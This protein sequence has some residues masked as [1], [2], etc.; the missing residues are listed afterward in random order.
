MK[1]KTIPRAVAGL[2]ALAVCLGNT[3]LT[4]LAAAPNETFTITTKAFSM[5]EGEYASIETTAAQPLEWSAANAKIVDV[6]GGVVYGKKQGSTK[7]T[8]KLDTVKKSV[9]V[10]VIRSTLR[11][12][13]GDITLY[14]GKDGAT[15]FKLKGTVRGAAKSV[16]F[17]SSDPGIATV[18]AKGSVTGVSEGTALITARAN[19]NYA[20]CKVN[21]LEKGI[22]LNNSSLNLATKG[23]G[24]SIKLTADVTGPK[25]SVK[26]TT[27]DKKV[28]TVSGGTVRGRKEGSAVITATANGVSTSCHVTVYGPET[29]M[30]QTAKG[31]RESKVFTTYG[32]SE[33]QVTL[34]AGMKRADTKQ[35]KSSAPKKDKP[36]WVSSD[37]N[38][39]QVN[40]NGKLTAVGAGT[41]YVCVTSDATG[42]TSGNCR[43]DV[44]AS[45]V[46][47]AEDSVTVKT[48]GAKQK[49]ALTSSVCGKKKN[50]TW[51]SSNTKV[52]TVSKGIVTGKKEGTAVITAT[53]NGVSD[54]VT[55]NVAAYDDT[56]R[57]ADE[58]EKPVVHV[59]TWSDWAVSVKAPAGGMGTESRY[60]TTCKAVQKRSYTAPEQEE[61][62]E[63]EK[64]ETPEVPGTPETPEKDPAE[65]KKPDC[66]Y[67]IT[68]ESHTW[69]EWKDDAEVT[70]K[71]GKGTKVRTCTVCGWKETKKPGS[72]YA[73]PGCMNELAPHIWGEWLWDS[74]E[75]NARGKKTESR[76]C[77]V[78]GKNE[79]R[80]AAEEPKKDEEPKQD[81]DKKDE[82]PKKDDES[83]KEPVCAGD[84]APHTWG[85]WAYD[86]E[87][88]LSVGIE[89][90]SRICSVCNMKDLRKTELK[91]DDGDKKDDEGQKDDESQTG[92]D[93]KNDGDKKDDESGETSETV[94]HWTCACG[95]EFEDPDE[96]M[97]TRAYGEHRNNN[98]YA[99]IM[100]CVQQPGRKW[101]GPSGMTWEEMHKNDPIYHWTCACG[102]DF[103]DRD[104][105]E[106]RSNLNSHIW[107]ELPAWYAI[108]FSGDIAFGDSLCA[109][110]AHMW[111]EYPDRD[112][113]NLSE[114]VKM[115]VI[116]LLCT[117]CG[118]DVTDKATYIK[119]ETCCCD[120][121]G[122]DSFNIWVTPV[123][124]DKYIEPVYENGPKIHR[125][126][127]DPE[128]DGLE[129]FRYSKGKCCDVHGSSCNLSR[130]AANTEAGDN[131]QTGDNT[132]T[133]DNTQTGDN[134]TAV[135]EPGEPEVEEPAPEVPEKK[136]VIK[137][138]VHWC[139]GCGADFTDEAEWKKHAM[140]NIKKGMKA[141]ANYHRRIEEVEVYE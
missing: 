78:C 124:P 43:V 18:D 100:I 5:N 72:S 73:E 41:A 30:V 38:V 39:V 66:F 2:L 17:E 129:Y 9:N 104:E 94:Y 123:E 99:G 54:T 113:D 7:V 22:T 85:E 71:L 47:I 90:D 98:M 74:A 20:Y 10:R 49:Y 57:L 96:E 114:T 134:D 60:C 130:Q 29:V 108:Y 53:A 55:V 35:L 102:A 84:K 70:A 118:Y 40:A 14:V 13:K 135:T 82:E 92:E 77:V 8:A 11:L 44:K 115:G 128:H 80:D 109:R 141:C 137:Q 52:A 63:P 3:S 122:H 32:L 125:Y 12:N 68:G 19:N 31:M 64:P 111:I 46:D 107:H 131:T 37:E 110:T 28:A 59:H 15:S 61:P 75:S 127:A 42:Y 24:S 126:Y 51:K 33:S 58:A 67:D 117:A 132:E 4:A 62:E 6:D 79:Y 27:S 34:Y 133:G 45:T 36:Y 140:E 136:P 91:K 23:V 116:H 25:K 101:E 1:K 105:L 106:A 95:A 120:R 121:G 83:Q 81:E 138:I 87:E 93:Q 139:C 21:V 103:A 76:S 112:T 65:D 86:A 16:S 97:A 56:A 50:I 88:S 48:K 69:S 119:D 89:V 26:W